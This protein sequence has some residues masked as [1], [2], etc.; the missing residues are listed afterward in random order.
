MLLI[1]VR[2]WGVLGSTAPPP[3]TKVI[4]WSGNWFDVKIESIWD[5]YA[6]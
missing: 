1:S 2:S 5:R 4:A 3:L 6:W